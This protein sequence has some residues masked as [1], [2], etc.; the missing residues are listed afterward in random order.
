MLGKL[1]KYEFKAT[2]RVFLPLFGALIIL[3]LVNRL[4]EAMDMRTPVL[5]I[6]SISGTLM[7]AIG[8]I[9]LVLILQ[10]FRRNLLRDEGYLMFTLPVSTDSLIWSKL[11]VATIWT[12]VSVIVMA[13]GVAIMAATGDTW[14]QLGDL[15]RVIS[16]AFRGDFLN[17]TIILVEAL[18]TVIVSLFSFILM[19]YACMSLSLLVNRRRGG[20][21]FLMFIVISIIGQTIISI[22]AKTELLQGL[23][24][25]IDTIQHPFAQA[26]S[27]IGLVLLYSLVTGA[28]F[29]LITRYML[30]R[31]L[32][33]E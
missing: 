1:M 24:R 6:S 17:L 5:I 20:F 21:A 18:A 9:S 3:A 25:A 12:V 32:N 29:Y 19:L 14:R 8:I 33:L 23:M 4:F 30:R 16:Q 2:G 22:I 11:L 26:Q 28:V 27:A 7:F 31:R 15:M 13:L 10:R